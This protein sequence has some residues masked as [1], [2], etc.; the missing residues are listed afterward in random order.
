MTGLGS[1]GP[2]QNPAPLTSPLE[3][4]S[5]A[6]LGVGATPRKAERWGLDW[7]HSGVLAAGVARTWDIQGGRPRP[8]VTEKPPRRT[9]RNL[10]HF[11]R[12]SLSPGR[13][14]TGGSLGPR[15]GSATPWGPYGEEVTMGLSRQGTQLK[16]KAWMSVLVSSGVAVWHSL[17]ASV[18][19]PVN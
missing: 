1:S 3:E 10:R 2:G 4:Q 17:C 6:A 12:V 19:S 8:A 16:V 7:G 15:P 11:S 14:E 18:S 5:R 9:L 13:A